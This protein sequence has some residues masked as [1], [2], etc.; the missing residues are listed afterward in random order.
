MCVGIK[1][2]VPL[3]DMCVPVVDLCNVFCDKKVVAKNS[4]RQESIL[5]KKHPT[6]GYH[7]TCEAQAVRMLVQIA[8]EEDEETNLV[9]IFTKLLAGPKPWDLSQD[10]SN[11]N[12]MAF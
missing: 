10:I 1:V 8:E 4:T 11:G 9:D 7:C 12:G 3:Q 5:K 2:K 6:M